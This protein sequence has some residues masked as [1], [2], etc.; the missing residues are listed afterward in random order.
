MKECPFVQSPLDIVLHGLHELDLAWNDSFRTDL[1][2]LLDNHS[3]QLFE[4]TTER[5]TVIEKL[6][7][8]T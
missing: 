7:Y 4:F 8:R 2:V 3:S 1:V 6:W 5:R